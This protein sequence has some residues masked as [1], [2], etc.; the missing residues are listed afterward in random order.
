[1]PTAYRRTRSVPGPWRAEEAAL[2]L[3]SVPRR[4]A[5]LA[6]WL[7]VLRS[8]SSAI[9]A[10][11]SKAQAATDFLFEHEIPQAVAA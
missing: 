6:S 8:D 4:T 2:Q 9:F 1:M 7:R 3:D 11:A 10:A 5:H